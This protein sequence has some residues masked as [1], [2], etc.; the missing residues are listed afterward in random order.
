MGYY[1][2]C[3]RDI[4]EIFV[5]IWGFSGM[6]QRMLPIEFYPKF[7][8]DPRCNGNEIWDKMGYNSTYVRDISEI[9]ASNN[10]F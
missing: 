10:S 8:T 3:V 7:P 4:C 5:S 1:S 2:A 6:G 9:L